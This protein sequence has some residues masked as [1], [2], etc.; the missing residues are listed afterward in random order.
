MLLHVAI[1]SRSHNQ[2]AANKLIIE[3]AK[4]GNR[5]MFNDGLK[6]LNAYFEDI[7]EIFN[8][9]WNESIPK[10]YLNFRTFIMGVQGNDEIFPNKM[11]YK[12]CYDNV[13]Q[14]FRGE[15]GAQ[16]SIIPATDSALG[17]VY[18]QNQLT[19][20]LWELR[21]YR[22]FPHQEYVSNLAKASKEHGV[23]SFAMKDSHSAYLMLVSMHQTFAFRHMHW[24]MVKK[25]IHDNT[26]Y[27]KATGGTPITTW[28]PNQ[29]GA[30]LEMCQNFI[31][32]IDAG[33][34]SPE[35]K[36]DYVVRKD[37]IETQIANLFAEV[38]GLQKDFKNQ[39]HEQFTTRKK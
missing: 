27:A 19:Q 20:Y 5:E 7:L 39:E 6:K 10:N 28:L 24:G 35:V 2:V 9:M 26:K 32:S 17:L 30:C 11:L 15:T 14:A 33:K 13:P 3:G 38:Q 31:S 18:P 12:G 36:A 21:A 37:T 4:A 34:L 23:A 16:D 8:L 29:M 22:P 25:Y 1:V